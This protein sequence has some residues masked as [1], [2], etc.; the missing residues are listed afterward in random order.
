MK[1]S[2]RYCY[3]RD[4]IYSFDL[5]IKLIPDICLKQHPETPTV[6]ALEAKLKA[7]DTISL[8][9]LTNTIKADQ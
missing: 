7:G 2:Y 9:D 4:Y 3:N 6:D 1:Q 8:V 5:Y